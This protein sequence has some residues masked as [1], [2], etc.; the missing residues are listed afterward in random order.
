M[1]QMPGY[2]LPPLVL[3]ESL[4]EG[5]WSTGTTNKY[6]YH[7]IFHFRLSNAWL[8]FCLILAY[9]CCDES[10]FYI[11]IWFAF[12]NSFIWC[13]FSW[14]PMHRNPK[15]QNKTLPTHDRVSKHMNIQSDLALNE[16]LL[17][18][19]RFSC[20]LKIYFILYYVFF[21]HREK[22]LLIVYQNDEQFTWLQKYGNNMVFC[23]A[24]YKGMY[25]W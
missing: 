10:Y 24:S 3:D 14:C 16:G 20:L 12:Q 13:S 22:P 5:K 6:F 8:L 23:D 15:G 21:F 9:F 1:L 11:S 17:R 2:L 18:V 25:S 7:T 4:K 19:L